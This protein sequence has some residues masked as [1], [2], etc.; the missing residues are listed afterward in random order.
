L[1]VIIHKNFFAYTPVVLATCLSSPTTDHPSTPCSCP[2]F[3]FLT[4]K[5]SVVPALTML[6]N[7]QQNASALA[8][9][10]VGRFTQVMSS[11]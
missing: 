4:L 6:G 9:Q 11:D 5:S 7:K 1:V 8:A 2:Y 3:V 10:S